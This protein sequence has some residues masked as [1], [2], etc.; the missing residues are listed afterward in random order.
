M[1]WRQTIHP[2]QS[3]HPI[4]TPTLTPATSS[5]TDMMPGGAG[6]GGIIMN[7]GNMNMGGMNVS[8]W[9]QDGV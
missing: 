3:T 5:S 4:P 8:T 7:A 6:G 2:A 9:A 1:L